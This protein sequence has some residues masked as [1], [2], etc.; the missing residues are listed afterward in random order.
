MSFIPPQLAAPA[1]KLA[2][3][4]AASAAGAIKNAISPLQQK[5]EKTAKD[6]ES[7]F[8]ENILSQAFPQEP[9]EGPLGDNGTGGQVYRGM[10][11][12][13]M[14]KQVAKAG[15]VGISDMVYR[16]M[17]QMQERSNAR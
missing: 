1:A 11:V 6:F 14:S 8:L 2:L 13:E 17:L 10:L 16:Q 3:G 9:G 7:M 5:T 4:V 15:G 12:N